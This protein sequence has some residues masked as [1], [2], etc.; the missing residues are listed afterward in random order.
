MP[1]QDTTRSELPAIRAVIDAIM[2][3]VRTGDVESYLRHAAPDLVVFDLVPPLEQKGADAFR[4]SWA[5]AL[6][7]FEGPIEY[8]IDHLDISMSGDMAFSRS[9]V[10]FGGT[11]KEGTRVINHLRSTIVFRKIEGEWKVIHSHVSVPFDMRNG[12]ALLQLET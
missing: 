10:H 1:E 3:A 6:G 5:I 11:T 4:R 8:E 9:L 7:S 12:K 2:K